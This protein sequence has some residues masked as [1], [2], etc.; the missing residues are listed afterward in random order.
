MVNH[1]LLHPQE[2]ETFYVIPTIRKHFAAALIKQG[3]MQKD[4]AK[5]FGITTSSISQYTSKKRGNELEFT[6]D[7]LYE[8]ENSAKKI[9]DQGS[10]IAE[11]QRLLRYIRTSKTICNIHKMFSDMPADC[12]PDAIGCGHSTYKAMIK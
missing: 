8:I 2:I 4:V 3:M 1:K 12:N 11:T 6:K 7:V 10:Y 5:I 9:K